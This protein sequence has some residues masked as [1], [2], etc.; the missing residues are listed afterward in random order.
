MQSFDTWYK[1]DFDDL[2]K[3]QVIQEIIKRFHL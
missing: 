1:E 3:E 2:N